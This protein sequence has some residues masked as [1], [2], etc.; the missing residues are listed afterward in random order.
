[1][2]AD[3]HFLV[4][5]HPRH[6]NV[7]LAGGFSG[8]GFKFSSVIGEILADLTLDGATKHPIGFLGLGRFTSF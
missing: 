1:M 5:R 2:T 8:H 7:V 4:D 3:E 6:P